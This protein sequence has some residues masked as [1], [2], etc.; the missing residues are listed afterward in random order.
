MRYINNA[1][2]RA[3]GSG[4]PDTA[5]VAAGPTAVI[6]PKA[7]AATCIRRYGKMA[8]KKTAT[9]KK[10]SAAPAKKTTAAK[11]AP[12]A[13]KKALAKHEDKKVFIS[14]DDAYWF[15]NGTHYQIYKKLGSHPS[16]EN[17][18]KGIFFAVWAPNAK[19]VDRTSVG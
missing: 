5:A 13:V 18:E 2:D 11:A 12:K 1:Q 10:S 17:G 15:G 4:Y 9:T 6:P 19:A 14:N 7:S 16:E 8:V 3:R